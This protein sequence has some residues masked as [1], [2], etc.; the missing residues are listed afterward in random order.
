MHTEVASLQSE[1]MK[2]ARPPQLWLDADLSTPEK[3]LWVAVILQTV[4]EYEEWARRIDRFH[5]VMKTE[6]PI[7][8]QE[9]L[10]VVRRECMHQW[11]QHVCDMA[12]VRPSQVFE[13][14]KVIDR[15]Y[16]V[17]HVPFAE[18]RLSC[19]VALHIRKAAR[20]ALKD[21]N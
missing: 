18:T 9:A 11:F 4:A 6:V 21:R 10:E 16:C 13:R 8:F 15:D 19:D 17:N 5:A 20:R 14:F 12:E 7:E 1:P 3:R 2:L